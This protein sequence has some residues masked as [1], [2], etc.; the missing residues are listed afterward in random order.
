MID[1]PEPK[2]RLEEF[3]SWVQQ[4]CMALQTVARE[5]PSV[6]ELYLNGERIGEVGQR[7]P[8]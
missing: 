3:T 5:T 6:T 2:E 1:S 7:A 4:A 8:A